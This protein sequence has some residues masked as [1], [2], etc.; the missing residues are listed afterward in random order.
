M[1]PQTVQDMALRQA[2]VERDFGLRPSRSNL[3]RTQLPAEEPEAVEPTPI[4]TST[5]SQEA[6]SPQ[7]SPTL[8]PHGTQGDDRSSTISPAKVHKDLPPILNKPTKR[9]RSDESRSSDEIPTLPPNFPPCPIERPDSRAVAFWR[10]ACNAAKDADGNV[11]GFDAVRY[12]LM[13][14]GGL[15]NPTPYLPDDSEAVKNMRK[16]TIDVDKIQRRQQEEDEIARAKEERRQANKRRYRPRGQNCM[17]KKKKLPMPLQT[18]LKLLL[19][20]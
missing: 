8:P 2:A 14:P 7:D 4:E 3:L 18:M 6:D 13:R 12:L 1:S 5:S 10:D 20:S 11:S 15:G 17:K 16:G 19:P 9:R